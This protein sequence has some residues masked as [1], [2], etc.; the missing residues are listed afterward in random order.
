MNMVSTCHGR[1]AQTAASGK[2]SPAINV[3]LLLSGSI[4]A[5]L[6]KCS[7]LRV[8]KADH[9]NL[10]GP[11][12]DKLFHAILLEDLSFAENSLHGILDGKQVINLRNLV[13]LDLG[14]NRLHGNIP[15]SIGQLKR[16]EEIHL[17]DN[18]MS[19]ELPSALSNCTN[20]IIIDLK[21]NNFSGELHKV[22]FSNL[23]YLK[24]LDLLYNNFT[25]TI[26]ESMYSCS[27]LTALRLS[28]NNLHGQLSPRISNLK[29]L[30]FLSI[31]LNNFTNIR[32]TLKI[33]R[34][35]TNL[36][37]LL[38]GANFKDETMPEDE[39]IDGFQNLRYRRITTFPKTL[40]LSHNNFTGVIPL[41]IIQLKLVTKLNFSFN[42]L[43]GEIPQQLGN[44]TSLQVLDLSSNHLTAYPKLLK[45]LI[46]P[47]NI[48]TEEQHL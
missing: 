34:N 36:T 13:N 14:G 48:W 12:P 9:N 32:H 20:I 3:E 29:S 33:L 23:P 47:Q 15:D 1:M 22:N 43:S 17:D 26:P 11:I 37:F 46:S 18:N 19:G 2:A 44:L 4:P 10:S 5:N 31:G 40:D 25:G 45:Y 41:E 24:T 42:G 7:A 6:G 8:L 21:S 30:V 39:T 28:G 38:M 27:N 16:L 35:S